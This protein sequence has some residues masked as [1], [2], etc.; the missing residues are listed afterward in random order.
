MGLKIADQSKLKVF[1]KT[2]CRQGKE[3][4]VGEKGLSGGLCV[5]VCVCIGMGGGWPGRGQGRDLPPAAS[6]VCVTVVL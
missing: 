6:E 1:V 5:C 2:Q 4:L 3:S